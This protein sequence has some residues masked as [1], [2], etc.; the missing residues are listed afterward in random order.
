MIV[1]C[2]TCA[3]RYDLAEHRHSSAELTITCQNCGNRW[4]EMP[5]HIPL[6]DVVD[7]PSRA[8]ARVIDYTGDEPELDVQRLVEA[9]K[10]AQEEFALQRR[11]RSKRL[12][13]WASLVVFTAAPFIA[14][15]FMPETVV[16]A[17]PI[18]FKAYEKLGY[19]VNIYG[20]DIRHIEQEHKTIDGKRVLMIKGEISNATN[21]IR[22]I[23]WLRFGLSDEKQELYSW[24]LDTAS[25]PLR[26]GET[27]SFVTRVAAAP[28]LAKNLQIRF[29]HPEEISSIAKP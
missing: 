4:R 20:L 19:T 9:A 11:A 5:R 12:S 15:A 29:A 28:E 26:P 18:T 17:A 23:P 16:A 6:I 7:V 24:T 2:P 25:R 3:S 27:T 1:S 21:D 22:K 14:A 8:V 10:S 13:G